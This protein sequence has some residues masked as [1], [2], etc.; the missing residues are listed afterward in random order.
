MTHVTKILGCAGAGKSSKT[1]EL[2]EEAFADGVHPDE[3]CI[4]S[5]A[6]A[7]V[8]D[9]FERLEEAVEKNDELPESFLYDGDVA[10]YGVT[11]S[12]I[13]A[14]CLRMALSED[15]QR[16]RLI[17]LRDKGDEEIFREFF[18]EEMSWYS[19]TTP[20]EEDFEISSSGAKMVKAYNDIRALGAQ[21]IGDVA[22]LS[23]GRDLGCPRPDFLE[24]VA[25]WTIWKRETGNR[26]HN[27]YIAYVRKH[28]LV[29]RRLVADEEESDRLK[30]LV[31]DEF[32]D[33]S[34]LQYEVYTMW[35]DSGNIDRIIIAGDA[36]QSIYGF[37]GAN[38]DYLVRTHADETIELPKSYRCAPEV[39]DYADK[40]IRG[41]GYFSET[42]TSSRNNIRGFVDE[43]YSVDDM[44]GV[45]R[46]V[47]KHTETVHETFLLA[48]RRRDVRR[49]AKELNK[50]GIP[51]T[52]V[53]PAAAEKHEGLWYWDKPLP[54]LRML[55]K[56]WEEGRN[57][58]KNWVETFLKNTT[59]E[60]EY[61]YRLGVFDTVLASE[62][63]APE[64]IQGV[65]Y[66]AEVMNFVTEGLS[67]AQTLE[68]LDLD[69][70]RV[71]ALKNAL[72]SKVN[73]GPSQVKVGTIHS[74]KGL[75]AESCIIFGDVTDGRHSMLIDDPVAL[76]EEKRLYHVGVTRA[77]NKVFIVSG[78][79]GSERSPALS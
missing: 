35:R 60:N 23:H 10:D 7:A 43:K 44:N 51:H 19:F 62:D 25:R 37:N 74:A 58:D 63:D 48:R 1:Q 70:G 17:S 4:L 16:K 40:L 47:K 30:V 24:F 66:P 9:I 41:E 5:Y 79:F 61:T 39:I 78:V 8:L 34:P 69:D 26:Q 56:S 28:G 15:F 65:K 72:R 45:T 38:P 77:R 49:L 52:S 67:L 27:D 33:L 36:A 12:T 68:S 21:N 6:N 76:A 3:N 53:T 20:S 18:E 14:L 11:V 71:E 50:A 13:N 31:I 57:V 75:G 2:I 73:I 42:L 55:F 59:L 29:P 32:Q 64:L 22:E 46:L 54:Q